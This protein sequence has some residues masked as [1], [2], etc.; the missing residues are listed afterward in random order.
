MITHSRQV[1]HAEDAAIEW[2]ARLNSSNLTDSEEKEFYS[3]LELSEL[4]QAAYIKAEE[5]WTRGEVIQRVDN[6]ETKQ[7]IL[8]LFFSPYSWGA[9]CVCVLLVSFMYLNFNVPVMEDQTFQTAIGELQEREF[10]DGSHIAVNTNSVLNVKYGKASRTATLSKG[11]AF[12]DVQSDPGRPFSVY[13]EFG[14]VR[15]LGTRFSVRKTLNDVVVTV[16]EGRVEFGSGPLNNTTTQKVVLG[17]NQRSS[18]ELLKSGKSAQ[19]IN[20]DAALAWRKKQLIFDGEPLAKVVKD[21]NRYYQRDV[22]IAEKELAD[23]KVTAVIQL[24]SFDTAMLALTESLGIRAEYDA[25]TSSVKLL[26]GTP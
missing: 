19:Q 6:T 5:L 13:T 8:G 11:E 18:G 1:R 7:G 9:A 26:P 3:W 2:I 14:E 10:S 20:A 23:R 21:L 15:V 17:P 22:L 25:E 4:N 24:T 16:V 12:F